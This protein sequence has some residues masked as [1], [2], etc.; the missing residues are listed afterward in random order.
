MFAPSREIKF[1]ENIFLSTCVER[2]ELFQIANSHFPIV[3]PE[4]KQPRSHSAFCSSPFSL[5]DYFS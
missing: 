1:W 5:V 3:L 4:M 2:M